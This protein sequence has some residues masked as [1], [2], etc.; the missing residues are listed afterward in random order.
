MPP[1]KI[2]NLGRKVTNISENTQHFATK[3]AFF[4]HFVNYI[5]QH[6]DIMIQRESIFLALTIHEMMTEKEGFLYPLLVVIAVELVAFR[7]IEAVV[8][9]EF[10]FPRLPQFARLAPV[11]FLPIE[12]EQPAEEHAAQ[13]REMRHIIRR[14]SGY[15]AE[16]REQLDERVYYYEY[17]RTYRYREENDVHRHIGIEPTEGK[18]DAEDRTGSTDGWY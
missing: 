5:L 4:L 11:G 8:A 6:Q 10:G 7:T 13:V 16:A 18:Q 2:Q 1:I 17:A 15:R 14:E 3:S 9:T 12:D